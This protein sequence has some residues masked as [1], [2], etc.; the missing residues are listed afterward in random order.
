MIEW[1]CYTGE[2]T[3]AKP[4]LTWNSKLWKGENAQAAAPLFGIYATFC[5][6]GDLSFKFGD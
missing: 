6:F 1:L 4:F 2:R 5:K 3:D